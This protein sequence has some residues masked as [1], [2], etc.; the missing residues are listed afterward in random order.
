MTKIDIDSIENVQK[1]EEMEVDDEDQIVD[2]IIKI[3]NFVFK[4]R[5]TSNKI[6]E[7]NLKID[8]LENLS[9]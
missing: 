6:S 3:K 7:C 9:V 8:D 2:E 4:E 1:Y 5:K